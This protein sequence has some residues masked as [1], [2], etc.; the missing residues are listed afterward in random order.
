MQC[1][2]AVLVMGVEQ[3]TSGSNV[4]EANA[5]D[6]STDSATDSTDS[7]T[8]STL[9]C[10]GKFNQKG[11]P[12]ITSPHLGLQAMVTF[13]TITLH[14]MMSQMIHNEAMQSARIRHK[15]GSSIRIDRQP[16]GFIAYL[17]RG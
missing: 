9:V 16:Q 8:E 15:D 2:G 10:V 13:Q 4:T 3:R 6:S 5:A 7:T 17:E 11:I 14:Q 1:Q 12:Q